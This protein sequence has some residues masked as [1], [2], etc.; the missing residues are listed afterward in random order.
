MENTTLFNVQDLE[1]GEIENDS[2]EDENLKT[3][4]RLFMRKCIPKLQ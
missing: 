4:T 3:M 2:L 1:I